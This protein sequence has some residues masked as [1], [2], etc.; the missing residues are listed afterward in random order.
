[1]K[2]VILAA[3]VFLLAFSG[4]L[5]YFKSSRNVDLEPSAV[6]A[7]AQQIL[8]G[9]RPPEGL[10]GVIALTLEEGVEVVVFAPSL[11]KAKP[12]NL[13]GSDLRIVVVRPQTADPDFQDIK[14][15]VGKLQEL[16]NEQSET[17][18]ESVVLLSVGGRPYPGKAS[19]VKLKSNGAR[20]HEEITVLM[21]EQQPVVLIFTGPSETYNQAAR[22]Q[23][24]STLRAPETEELPGG[25]EMPDRLP[26][27][28][29]ELSG[30]PEKS[31]RP[32]VRSPELKPPIFRQKT[33]APPNPFRR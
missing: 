14:E 9:A 33:D 27:G 26:G 1:M 17:I 16:K 24:L 21:N 19:E 2:K 12:A 30:T 4:V 10:S 31:S 7:R 15:K 5:F 8:P 23:F 28:P 32:M 3:A 13:Q 11:A 25:L 18:S 22:D 20:Q 29:P 6:V